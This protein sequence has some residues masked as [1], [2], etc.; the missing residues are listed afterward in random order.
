MTTPSTAYHHTQPG[1]VILGAFALGMAIV[2]LGARSLAGSSPPGAVRTTI[3]TLVAVVAILVAIVTF[4]FS[5]LTIE[6]RDGS[7]QWHFT[8]RFIQGSVPLSRI[9]SVSRVRSSA[10]Y[11]WGARKTPDGTLYSVSGLDAV[12]IRTRDGRSLNFGTDEPTRLVQAIEDGVA[13][14]RVR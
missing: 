9:E 11:G 2:V 8:G 4:I 14:A 3:L 5:S 1:F 7:L 6:I 12:R 10:A 13:A